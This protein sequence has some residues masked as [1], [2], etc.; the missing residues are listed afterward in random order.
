ME[1]FEQLKAV[2][3]LLLNGEK[4]GHEKEISPLALA[5]IGDAVF[6]LLIR[7]IVICNGNAPVNKLHKKARDFVNAKSQAQMVF[8]MMENFTEE[9]KAVFRRGRNAKSFTVPKNADI[10]D[11]RHATGLE[12]VF[13]YLYL[14]GNL[15][16]AIEL[17]EIGL[18]QNK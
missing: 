2:K 14:S 17:L 10:M 5:Y 11:Y 18:L 15:D 13:G 4:L 3:G 6:E 7:S 16:R 8:R 1:Y 12:A 9:E